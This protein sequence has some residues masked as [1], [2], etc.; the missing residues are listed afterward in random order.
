MTF[1]VDLDDASM[2]LLARKTGVHQIMT[3]DRRDL[4]AYRLPGGKRFE[5]VLEVKGNR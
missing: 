3:L 4:L 2:V 5:L 1:P